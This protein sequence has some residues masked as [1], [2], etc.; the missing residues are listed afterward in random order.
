MPHRWELWPISNF[1]PEQLRSK[2]DPYIYLHGLTECRDSDEQELG[3]DGLCEII[4]SYEARPSD[5]RLAEIVK[6]L[7]ENEMQISDDV[8]M[9][10]ID[11]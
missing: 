4:A 8:T 9:I 2:T 7:R 11:S 5:L 6:R 1:R 3:V 10:V